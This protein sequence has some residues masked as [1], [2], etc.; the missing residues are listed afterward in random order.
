LTGF[1]E[2]KPEVFLGGIG[3]CP[4][5]SQRAFLYFG[6]AKNCAK[7]VIGIQVIRQNL[8]YL[9]TQIAVSHK[10]GFA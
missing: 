2:Q 9:T 3:N 1:A 5:A 10:T 6:F 8:N 7:I 4:L